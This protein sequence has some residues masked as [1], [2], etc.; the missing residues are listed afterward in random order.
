MADATIIDALVVTLGLDTAGFEKGRKQAAADLLRLR[1]TAKTTTGDIESYGKR[2]ANY[3]GSLRNEVVGLFLAFAGAKGIGDFAA[4]II[5][6]DAATGRLAANL[7]VAT[8]ALSAWEGA[9]RRVGGSSSDVD[10]AFR[11]ITGANQNRALTGTTGHDADFQGL[12]VTAADLASPTQALLK[13]ADAGERL[14]RPEFVARLQRI[15]IPENTINLLE[16]GRKGVEQLVEEQRR[17]GVVTDQDAQAAERLQD[18]WGRLYGAMQGQL[19]PVLTTIVSKLLDLNDAAGGVNF[20]LPVMTGL[21]G[22][23]AIAAIAAAGPF[24]ALAAAIGTVVFAYERFQSKLGAKLPHDMAAWDL[25]KKGDFSGAWKEFSYDPA[26]HPTGGASASG[27]GNIRD[28]FQRN[29][30]TAGQTD[31]IYAGIMAE[32]GGNP[33]ARNPTSGA[34]GIGQWLGPR[35]AALFAKYGPNPTLDQ[36]LRFLLSELQGGDPGGAAVRRSRGGSDTLSAYVNKFMRPGPG[37]GGDMRRGA[38]YLAGGRG[39]ASGNTTVNIHGMTIHAP[40]AQGVAN[41][42]P[43]A[44]KRRGITVHANSGLS[45]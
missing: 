1:D 42:L 9:V 37:A 20:V 38:R 5:S 27:G 13:M 30:F 6:G 31:G 44:I 21:L 33:N 17:A 7:G 28:F 29:G 36:Q 26:A 25:L 22:A 34:Y 2:A 3:F 11:I 45:G 4:Q 10:S 35:K 32:S 39:R 8:E 18:R 24:I 23:T 16:R 43:A 12:G 19:R 40:D 15:G 41:Q 14:S